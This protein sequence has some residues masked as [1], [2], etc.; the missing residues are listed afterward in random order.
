MN[1]LGLTIRPGS[2]DIP[3]DNDVIS[4]QDPPYNMTSRSKRDIE[5]IIKSETFIDN[6][7]HKRE[8]VNM[9]G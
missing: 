5:M 8:I 6:D 1:P 9:V 7:G 2:Q 4:Y 3:I